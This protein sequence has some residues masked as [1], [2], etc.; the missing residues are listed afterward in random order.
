MG[1]ISPE[2]T[3]L[4]ARWSEGDQKALE[5][6]TPLVYGELRRLARGYM[7]RERPGHTLQATALV[8]EAFLRLFGW[9]EADWKDRQHFFAVSARLMRHVLVDR[10]RSRGY[11]KRG[12]EM[13]RVL[14]EDAAIAAKVSDPDYVELDEALQRLEK[15]DP[16]KGQ[17]VELS[18]FGGLTA[19]EVA[20]VLDISPS[21]VMR[22][23]KFA[24]AW[25]RRNMARKKEDQ[26]RS[27]QTD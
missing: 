14:I 6:L 16:R 26:A 11:V 4:L 15:M 24:R 8:N 20:Q 7:A 2:V 18:Y 10:A 17:I 13:Q 19:E 12:G 5:E 21:T 3:L 27:T 25:L 23:L 1:E 9:K 22:D